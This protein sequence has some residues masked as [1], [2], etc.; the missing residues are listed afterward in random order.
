MWVSTLPDDP[1][2]ASWWRRQEHQARR[3]AAVGR[4]RRRGRVSRRVREVDRKLAAVSAAAEVRSARELLPPSKRASFDRGL[5]ASARDAAVE[6]RGEW[7][8]DDGT[9]WRP[10][11]AHGIE[12]AERRTAR[13]GQLE[14]SVHR[15]QVLRVW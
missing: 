5:T 12:V 8:Y 11:G 14:Y 1:V 9:W 6:S 7:S 10:G 15:G 4:A 13:P 3:E 2:V